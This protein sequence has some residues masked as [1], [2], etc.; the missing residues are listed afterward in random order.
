MEEITKVCTGCG[1][2]KP[3]DEFY[4]LNSGKY[5]RAAMCKTCRKE[6]DKNP[7]KVKARAKQ[8]KEEIKVKTTSKTCTKCKKDKPLEEYHKDKTKN[9]GRACRCNSC[10]KKYYERNKKRINIRVKKYAKKHKRERKVY[11][12]EYVKEHKKEINLRTKKWE[13]QRYKKDFLFRLKK[14]IAENIRQ[15]FI[16][17][18]WK[19]SGRTQKILGCTFKEF[20]AHLNNNRYGFNWEDGGFDL[21]HFVPISWAKTEKEI[22]ELNH[23]TNF[24]LLPSEFNRHIKRD[25]APNSNRLYSYLVADNKYTNAGWNI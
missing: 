11:Q 2:D 1:L 18:G 21:D 9:D 12:R 10:Y 13:K 20:L 17:K 8:I 16:N 19:K 25:Y 7:E 5:G 4:K 24:Q 14:N 23:Y 6:Y 15:S 22:L 3:L